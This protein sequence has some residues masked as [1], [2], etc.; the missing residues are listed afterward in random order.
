MAAAPGF[1]NFVCILL[2][3]SGLIAFLDAEGHRNFHGLWKPLN[4]P[5]P[6]NNLPLFLSCSTTTTYTSIHLSSYNIY[7]RRPVL[8]PSF[9]AVIVQQWFL[10]KSQFKENV[11]ETTY[12]GLI[13]ENETIVELEPQLRVN[14]ERKVC[15]FHILRNTH[16]GG[17]IPFQVS[18][19]PGSYSTFWLGSS[20]SHRDQAKQGHLGANE[21]LTNYRS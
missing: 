5:V 2:V 19:S 8:L 15:G 17:D 14:D 3:I 13:K 6:E 10:G 1:R 9:L 16:K 18:P 4:S 11:L 21:G 20:H 7:N 12:H